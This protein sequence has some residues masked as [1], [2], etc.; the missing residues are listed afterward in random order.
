MA[1]K[2]QKLLS[3]VLALSMCMSL[4]SVTALAEGEDETTSAKSEFSAPAGNDGDGTGTVDD[5]NLKIT[6]TSTTENGTTTTTTKKEWEGQ[7]PQEKDPD[8]V[9][10]PVDPEAPV[11]KVEGTEITKETEVKDASG[12]LL[13]ESGK[14]DGQES[15]TTTTTTTKT[16]NQSNDKK[17]ESS[18][19]EGEESPPT[20][21]FKIS[22]Q[23][24]EEK[25]SQDPTVMPEKSDVNFSGTSL[26]V[27]PGTSTPGEDNS[28]T[29]EGTVTEKQL[30]SVKSTLDIDDS[31][32][33]DEETGVLS[34]TESITGDDGKAIGTETTKV[35]PV[36]DDDDGKT[37]IGYKKTVTRS[38]LKSDP[39]SDSV[40]GTET[41]VE[42]SAKTEDD[43]KPVTTTVK[44][45]S[46]DPDYPTATEGDVTNEDGSVTTTTIEPI[47]DTLNEAD[48]EQIVGYK[49][50]TVTKKDGETVATTCKTNYGKVTTTTTVKQPK[51]TSTDYEQIV[52]TTTTKV[53]AESEDITTATV[54]PGSGTITVTMGSVQN[55]STTTTVSAFK[56]SDMYY[57]NDADDHFDTADQ[58]YNRVKDGNYGDAT[59]LDPTENGMKYTWY[60]EYGIESTIRV[61]EGSSYQ[62]HQFILRDADDNKQYVYCAD[63]DVEP[64]DPWKYDMENVTDAD[65]YGTTE[66]NHIRYIAENGFWGTESGMGSLETFK[67]MLVEKG[68][69]DSN[70]S[71]TAGEA[72]TATQAAIWFYGN[73]S[74]TNKLVANQIVGGTYYLDSKTNEKKVGTTADS[75]KATVQKIFN[76]LIRQEQEPEQKTTILDKNTIKSSTVKIGEKQENGYNA[77][78][79]FTL[80]VT[81][82]G[83]DAGALRLTLSYVDATTGES[84]SITKT[85]SEFDIGENGDTYTFT[86]LNIGNGTKLNLKLN[87]T[88]EL[89]T[90]V[91]LFSSEVRP[92]KGEPTSSQTFV[93]V[94]KGEQTVDLSVDL[95]IEW[96]DPDSVK[97]TTGSTMNWNKT[98]TSATERT[99]TITRTDYFDQITV[100]TTDV[101]KTD[102][103]WHSS[104][105]KKYSSRSDGDDDDE[106]PTPGGKKPTPTPGGEEPTP[107]GEKPTP[108]PEGSTPTTNIPGGTP[109]TSIPDGVPATNV[110]KT[111]DSSVLWY[112]L[113]ACSGLGLAGTALI[114][115]KRR[116]D[117]D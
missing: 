43:G 69:L 7:D 65:Y 64:H 60:G 74:T 70:E 83:K 13:E 18:V 99:D 106:N 109:T 86:G 48:G 102:W 105:E 16:E 35:E 33:E 81:P 68:V 82:S 38:E 87:G 34:K 92:Y 59:G 21:S 37:V 58:L 44:S 14:V 61:K 3:L 116:D 79:S 112:V 11:T 8:D 76:Y 89:E 4:L 49:V 100:T 10:T 114:G 25:P 15:L 28:K 45:L 107:E 57:K 47:K 39:T 78:V 77:S 103:E 5:P 95:T 29:V 96:K 67:A 12:K 6:E 30:D 71:L 36:Y 93:G 31:Y 84:T 53:Y 73:S 110:P 111:G 115:K 42:G 41:E 32:V 27:T 104:W 54:T 90:G 80:G 23:T 62:A 20:E 52:T 101:D 22:N 26:T 63:F 97:T 94:A 46:E 50:I 72:L 117:E 98:E 9:E 75:D 55:N 91:Y 88:H 17:S 40:Y 1:R 2:L 66:A 56:E 85:L 51:K 113:S 108:T 19:N 24:E